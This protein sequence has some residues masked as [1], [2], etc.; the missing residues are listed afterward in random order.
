MSFRLVTKG[1]FDKEF[2]RLPKELQRRVAD[3][4][5]ALREN[6]FPH[7]YVKLR[8]SEACRLRVGDYRILYWPDLENKVIRLLAVGRRR[9]IYR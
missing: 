1:S 4:F 7:G 2:S 5:L 9:E 8:A 3:A 6:S